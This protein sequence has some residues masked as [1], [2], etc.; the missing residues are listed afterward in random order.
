MNSSHS[1][2]G[3]SEPNTAAVTASA[4]TTPPATPAACRTSLGLRPFTSQVA[5]RTGSTAT[6]FGLNITSTPSS[7]PATA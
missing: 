2:Q 7:A 6:R 1:G 4:T 3:A 5:P